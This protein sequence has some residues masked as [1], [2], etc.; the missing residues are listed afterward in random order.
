MDLGQLRVRDHFPV[1]RIEV[2]DRD[3]A[4]LSRQGVREDVVD[5]LR[6][7]GYRYVTLDLQGFRSGSLNEELDR[8]S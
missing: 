3:I 8:K 7:L 6:A 4:C 2:S 5:A 1:A